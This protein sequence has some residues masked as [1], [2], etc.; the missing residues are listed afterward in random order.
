M[1]LSRRADVSKC[2][3]LSGTGGVNSSRYDACVIGA[4]AEGLA[5]AIVLAKAGLR[6]AVIE[7]SAQPGGRCATREFHPGFR[8][9]PFA[10]ELAPIPSNLYWKLGLAR[11]GAFFLP[12]PLSTAI[13]PDRVDILDVSATSGASRLGTQVCDF[14]RSILARAFREAESPAPGWRFWSRSR[15]PA[16]PWPG[17]AWLRRTL[18]DI[19]HD[20][21][22]SEDQAAHL[23]AAALAGRAVDPCLGGSALHL[24]APGAGG[25]GLIVGGFASLANALISAAREAGVEIVL[26]VEVSDVRHRQGRLQGVGLSNGTEMAAS[27]VVSSLDFK[28]TLLSLFTW[29]GLPAAVI[30]RAGEYRTNGG[31]ARVLLAL[32]RPPEL[33]ATLVSPEI[34]RGPIYVAPDRAAFGAAYA[35]WRA[36]TIPEQPPAVLRLVSALDPRLAPVGGATMTVTLGCIPARLFDGAWTR[37]RREHLLARALAAA[38][39]AVPGTRERV[40]GAEVIVPPD[41][42]AELGSTDGDL[43]GGEI[44]ADQMF[45]FRPWGDP[46]LAISP[47]TPIDGLYLAG[48]SSAAGPFATCASGAIAAAAVIADRM[49]GRIR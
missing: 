28:R 44:A 25:S 15:S 36:G 3:Q 27:V 31:M 19:F 20:R 7:R 49:A 41:I 22:L 12:A 8:A 13:W 38:E 6:T 9:S 29:N 14:Q 2:G 16:P 11:H 23:A 18:D 35:S 34:F 26:G 39:K 17:A 45:G 10:D 4:G 37:E 42:E 30:R 46:A 33:P 43:L 47:R 1:G 32:E 24:L 40:V 5:A 48:P 21:M